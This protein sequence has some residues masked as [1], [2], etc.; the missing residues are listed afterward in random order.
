MTDAQN[1]IDFNVDELLRKSPPPSTGIE[2]NVD[3][4]LRIRPRH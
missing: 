2:I 1:G 4:L 3:E